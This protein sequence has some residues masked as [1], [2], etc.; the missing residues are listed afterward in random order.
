MGEC[1]AMRPEAAD[2]S[3]LW[4]GIKPNDRTK[5]NIAIV[6]IN[7]PLEHHATW[8]WDSYEAII[9]RFESALTG[10]DMVDAEIRSVTAGGWLPLPKDYEPPAPIPASAVVLL[11]DSPGGEAAGATW[12]HRK[13]QSLK[14]RYGTPVYAYANEMACSAAYEIAC[15]CDEIWLPDTGAVG[16]IGV[17]ATLFD[18]TRQNEKMGLNV[19]LITSGEFKADGHADRP[20]TDEIRERMQDRVMVLAN[21]FFRTVASARGTTP[22]AIA[23]LEAGVFIGEDAV[24]VGIADNIA[25]YGKFLRTIAKTLD[26][27]TDDAAEPSAA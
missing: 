14:K 23:E 17:I 21:I 5:D 11:T 4:T 6:D 12:C 19:E 7:G 26:N 1:L 9:E 15:A 2:F 10:Q 25:D 13:I 8:M 20:I 24:D 3:F 27:E 16:S 18:R 22:K